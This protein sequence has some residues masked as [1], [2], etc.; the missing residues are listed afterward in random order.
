MGGGTG[1]HGQ[2]VVLTYAG[3]VVLTAWTHVGGPQR[4]PVRGRDD[5]DVAAVVVMQLPDHHRSTPGVGPGVATRSV[6]IGVP[7]RLTWL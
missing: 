7:S 1:D 6:A 4:P 5:L 3:G 2:N